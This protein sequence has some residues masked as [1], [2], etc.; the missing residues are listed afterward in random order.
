ML[1]HDVILAPDAKPSQSLMILH[2]LLGQGQN[3]RTM[4]RKIVQVKPE[5][6]VILPDLR[7][8]GS[9]LEMPGPDT[10][11]QAATDAIELAESEPGGVPVRAILGHSLGG[12]IALEW[13]LQSPVER[14]FVVD[15][16]PSPRSATEGTLKIVETLEDNPGPFSTKADFIAAMS[17]EPSVITMVAQWLATS[18]IES[19]GGYRFGPPLPAIRELMASFAERDLWHALNAPESSIHA[20]LGSRSD[21]RNEADDRRLEQLAEGSNGRVT[22]ESLP[23]GHWVHVD[24][25]AGVLSAVTSRL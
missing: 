21:L 11:P 15:S 23:A 9:S 19:D 14:A 24:D 2:G 8:H 16:T 18:L 4:A 12:K 20:L 17:R 22:V 7:R 5:W 3:W 1:A 10:L 13:L 25:P 6:A